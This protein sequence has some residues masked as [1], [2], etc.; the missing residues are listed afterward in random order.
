MIDINTIQI[1]YKQARIYVSK[2]SDSKET[3]N[4]Y[5]FEYEKQRSSWYCSSRYELSYN[6]MS[7]MIVSLSYIKIRN[8]FN[9]TYKMTSDTEL[10]FDTIEDAEA[11]FEWLKQKVFET[12]LVGADT[13]KEI[14]NRKRQ[15]NAAKR[16]A[17]E[18]KK[19]VDEANHNIKTFNNHIGKT[20]TIPLYS[21]SD[22]LKVPVTLLG[23]TID[24]KLFYH[25]ETSIGTIRFYHKSVKFD[26][27]GIIS[28][29]HQSS[30]P[31]V[32]IS[33]R[34]NIKY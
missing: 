5:Y 27:T 24:D 4:F 25:L 15:E 33:G 8:I 19:A 32:L 18:L 9:K 29:S 22:E 16:E 3:K 17:K 23:L 7:R 21:G 1:K 6:D 11:A 2:D 20:I 14:E 28:Y 10:Y 26:D 12:T 34:L 30:E 31:R 13:L